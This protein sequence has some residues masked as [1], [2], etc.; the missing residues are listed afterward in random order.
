MH[1]GMCLFVL[2]FA[3]GLAAGGR[4]QAPSRTIVITLDDLPFVAYGM[5]LRGIREKTGA[6]LSALQTHRVPALGLVTGQAVEVGGEVRER[7]ALLGEWRKAGAELGNHGYAH[8]DLNKASLESYQADFLKCDALLRRILG[9]G[10]PSPRFFRHPLTHTGAD[11]ETKLSFDRFLGRQGYQAIPF[12]VENADYIFASLYAKAQSRGDQ[13]LGIRLKQADLEHLD[14]AL[15]FFEGCAEELF[16]RPIPQVLLLHANELNSDLMD[17]ILNRLEARGYRYVS[18]EDALKDPA[19]ATS[20]GYIGTKGPSWIHRWS[21]TLAGRWRLEEEP[22]PPKW[23]LDLF[24][25]R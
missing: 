19:Y 24:Q 6:L 22:D 5:D 10:A 9:R 3:L 20:D 4:T 16:H 15:A 8:L 14:T 2:F 11:K 21:L 25:A 13:G 18:L 7:E 17:A 12:T 1:P 23:V